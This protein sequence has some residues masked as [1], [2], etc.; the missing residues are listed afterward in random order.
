MSDNKSHQIRIGIIIAVIGTV[1]GGI[2]LTLIV[3]PLKSLALKLLG[4]IWSG[5][6][7][8]GNKIIASYSL[9]G[10]ILIILFFLAF[11]GIIKI[12][13]GFSSDKKSVDIV[14]ELN[15][16]YIEDFIFGVKWRWKWE[17]NKIS[18][19]WCQCP[20]CDAILV[21]TYDYYG[22]KI[23]LVCEHCS[24]QVVATIEGGDIDY[25]IG[26]AKREIL[27]RVQTGEF[28]KHVQTHDVS[29]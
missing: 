2:I 23:N 10:W 15:K 21:Y 13:L 26:A 3:E 12:Y 8:V 17:K 28:K 9:P 19:L 20:R 7:W 11:K 22:P 27:R 29:E 16:I 5:L 6:V 24:N 1:I 18:N 14:D 4:S 25:A